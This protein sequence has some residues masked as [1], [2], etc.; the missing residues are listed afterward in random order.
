[1]LYI[2]NLVENHH[3]CH[4]RLLSSVLVEDDD[5]SRRA[6]LPAISRSER[7]AMLATLRASRPAAF[8]AA[9]ADAERL[10]EP[11]DW[12]HLNQDLTLTVVGLGEV[13]GA[14]DAA[15]CEMAS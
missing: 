6:V 5:D 1:M 8:D 7:A 4:L 11:V 14:V 9:M 10:L 13:A 15:G 12:D 3:R 2:V